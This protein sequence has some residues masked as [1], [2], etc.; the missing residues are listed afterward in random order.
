[1]KLYRVEWE[2]DEAPWPYRNCVFTDPEAAKER[3]FQGMMHLDGKH[4]DQY[5][6]K[7][8]HDWWLSELHDGGERSYEEWV[9]YIVDECM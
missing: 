6:Y 5:D 4:F 2:F 9:R 7:Y 1:M 8:Y 3:I